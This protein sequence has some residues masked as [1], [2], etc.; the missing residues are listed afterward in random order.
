MAKRALEG[1]PGIKQAKVS[2]W[3]KKA[4][5]TYDPAQVTVARMVNALERV[6]YTARPL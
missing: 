1:L 3:S 2:L 6:G 5:V 4:I